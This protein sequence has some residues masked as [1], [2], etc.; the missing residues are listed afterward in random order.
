MPSEQSRRQ[1]DSPLLVAICLQALVAVPVA[2][3]EKQSHS[4]SQ[5]MIVQVDAPMIPAEFR[6][7]TKPLVWP[8]PL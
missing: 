2:G 4:F 7:E 3:A 8:V 1:A 5:R 6:Q